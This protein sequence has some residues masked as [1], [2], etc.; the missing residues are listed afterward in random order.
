MLPD[1]LGTILDFTA[2]AVFTEGKPG[3][4]LWDHTSPTTDGIKKGQNLLL[5][6]ATQHGNSSMSLPSLGTHNSVMEVK[7]EAPEETSFH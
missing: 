7:P 2:L 6:T 5:G 3:M 1:P 4:R